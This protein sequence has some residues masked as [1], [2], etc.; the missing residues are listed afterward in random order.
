VTEAQVFSRQWA[1]PSGVLGRILAEAVERVD[2]IPP[3]ER[4]A[5]VSR[6]ESVERVPSFVDAMRGSTVAIIAEVKRRSPSKGS[7]R[8]A[9]AAELQGEAYERGG[10][11]AISVLTE[12]AHF[13]GSLADL[14]STRARVAIPLL[15]KDFH[16]DE[17]QLYE[18]RSAGASA[19]LLIV[20][21]LPP[22]RLA[23]LMEAAAQLELEALVEAHTQSELALA[24]ELGARVIGINSRNLETLELDASVPERLLALIPSGAIAIAESG[25]STRAD[26]EGRAAWGADAVLVGSALSA[27]DDPETAVRTLSGVPRRVR[28]R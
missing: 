18:A 14:E 3:R 27:A 5:I 22:E 24:I 19:V 20:R 16:V 6:A 9:M 28:A 2:A 17:L 13:G 26:V 7:I 4:E 8:E 12:P 11:S 1:P 10:A 21:A 15:R 25:I 23:A